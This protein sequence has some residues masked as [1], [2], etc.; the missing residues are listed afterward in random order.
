MARFKGRKAPGSRVQGACGAVQGQQSC[1]FNG[2]KG[3]R[4][5]AAV[6]AV[7]WQQSCRFKSS[8]RR[9]RGSR[10][11]ELPV[12]GAQRR[13]VQEFNVAKPRFKGSMARVK[14]AKALVKVLNALSI[15]R[16]RS[17]IE[18]REAH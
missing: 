9:W 4:F 2:R 13:A 17:R 18:Q 14:G 7:Q 3:A 12:Q 5:K 1:R 15:E 16:Q 11:A 8:K 6:A 10:A